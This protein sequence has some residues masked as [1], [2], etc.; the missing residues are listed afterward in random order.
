[1]E[2]CG[3]EPHVFATINA[4]AAGMVERPQNGM[5]DSG[6][7]DEIVRAIRWLVVDALRADSSQPA[8]VAEI[9]EAIAGSETSAS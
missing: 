8:S 1:V 9:K 5:G 3:G 2:Q 6:I 4:L 7:K